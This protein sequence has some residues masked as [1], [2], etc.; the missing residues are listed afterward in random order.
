M[1]KVIK[2]VGFAIG[3]AC[4]VAGHYV[5]SFDFEAAGGLGCGEFTPDIGK[6]KIFPDA[7][8]AMRFWGTKS[9]T[10]PLRSDGKPNRPLTC[11]TVEIVNGPQQH[12][13]L[14]EPI[15]HDKDS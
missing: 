5:E 7:D 11:T 4:P 14:H 3:E 15:H 12:S 1:T 2:A 9:I 10:K 6:A 8:A 13:G